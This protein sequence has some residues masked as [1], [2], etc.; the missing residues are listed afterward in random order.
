MTPSP[1]PSVPAPTGPDQ[2]P[3]PGPAAEQPA[4]RYPVRRPPHPLAI[5]S[6]A[7]GVVGVAGLPLLGSFETNGWWVALP[8]I[9]SLLAVVSGHLAIRR[10]ARRDRTDRRLAASGLFAGYLGL[11]LLVAET[12]LLIGVLGLAAS[13]VSSTGG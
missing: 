4:S 13:I 5:A 8:T 9:A 6:I 10:I 2:A 3:G 12:V 11:T 7:T 1:L